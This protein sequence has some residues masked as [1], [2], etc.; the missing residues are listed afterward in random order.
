M[1]QILSILQTRPILFFLQ[2]NLPQT[3]TLLKIYFMYSFIFFYPYLFNTY[4]VQHSS[5]EK[6]W[7]DCHC[8]LSPNSLDSYFRFQIIPTFSTLSLPIHSV[9]LWNPA[10]LP[11][12]EYI[13][14]CMHLPF[15]SC[16]ATLLECPPPFSPSGDILPI[17]VCLVVVPYFP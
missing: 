15:C 6:C 12:H 14:L 9:E 13:C 17:S 1:S 8:L 10:R 2:L 5:S 7:M 3:I 11:F 16:Y 4:S